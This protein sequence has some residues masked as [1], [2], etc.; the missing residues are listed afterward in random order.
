MPSIESAEAE[1]GEDVMQPVATASTGKKRPPSPGEE[2]GDPPSQVRRVDPP[3]AMQVHADSQ[4]EVARNDDEL[5]MFAK[6]VAESDVKRG[7]G[8]HCHLCG[9][10]ML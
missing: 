10:M 5:E 2:S 8:D 1:A 4:E 3:L 7:G 9:T 6:G